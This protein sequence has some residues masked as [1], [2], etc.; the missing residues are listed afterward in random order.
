MRVSSSRPPFLAGVQGSTPP[1]AGRCARDKNIYPA[2]TKGFFAPPG[3]RRRELRRFSTFE[4]ESGRG[5][6]AQADMDDLILV[7][8]A[9][10]FV[11]S[12]VANAARAAGYRV[13]VLVRGSSPRTTIARGEAVIV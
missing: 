10:G 7:T 8:G 12:A 6:R 11:G 9:S 1:G 3:V 13:R 5:D 4:R 2:G